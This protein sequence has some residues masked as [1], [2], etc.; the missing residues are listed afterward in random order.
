MRTLPVS[1]FSPSC[2]RSCFSLS[3]ILIAALCS[4]LVGAPAMAQEAAPLSQTAQAAAAPRPLITQLVDESQLTVLKGNTYP[5]ALPQNDLGTAPASLPM[6]RMLLVLKRSPEQE[7]ALIRMLDNQ[8]DKESPSYHQWVTPEQF[9]KQFGPTDADMQIIVAWLQ[10][11]GFQVGTTKGRSVL[12]FSGSA[13]QVQEAFHTTIHKYLV[14]GE[15]HWANDRDPSIPTAL[16]PAV[17]GI[18]SLHNFRKKPQYVLSKEKG[19][20][21]PGKPPQVNFSNGS[22]AMGPG[23]FAVIYNVNPV[24]S[25][26]GVT[27]SGIT[28]GVIARSD[29]L[30]S[31]YSDFVNFYG[32]S[33]NT[34]NFV[35]N[36]PDP[37]DLL[38]G[39]DVEGTLDATWSQAL[40]PGATVDYVVSASTDTTDGIDLSEAYIVENNL[41]NIMT[42]SFGGCEAFSGDAQFTGTALLAEQAAAQGISYFVSTGDAGAEGC[43]NPNVEAVATGPISINL[44]ASTP[45]TV[46]VGGTEFNDTGNPAKYW[47]ASNG[48]NLVSALSYIP[49]VVWNDSCPASSCGS[50]EN[51]AAG[52]GGESTGNVI[53]GGT[54]PGFAKPAWQTGVTGIPSPNARYLPDVSLTASGHDGY[55]ICYQGS[56]AQGSIYVIGGTSAS[57]PSFAAIMALV[58]ERMG[59]VE[60][61][62]NDGTRQGQPDYM[63][64]PL[65]A[66]ENGSLSSCNGSST[67]TLPA[68][69][70]VFNDV[71]VGNNEV[72]GEPGYPSAP[73][74]STVGYD[75]AVGLGSVNVNNLVTKWASATFRAT[76]TALTV[77]P[78]TGITH[79]QAVNVTIGVTPGSGTGT[80]TGDVS[81]IAA[82][83]SSTSGETS[84]DGFTLAAN[85]TFSGST[86]Q[87]PGGTY[88]VWAHYAGNSISTSSG[89][90][91]ASDSSKV[92][93][94]VG[95][96]GSTT[97]FICNPGGT[98]LTGCGLTIDPTSGNFV[99][100]TS[101][102]TIPYG[103]M[104]YLHAAVAGT[105]GFGVPTGTVSIKDNAVAVAGSPFAL[106]SDGSAVTPDGL[107]TLPAGSASLIAAYNHD[108]SF[109]ASTS[110]ALN[111]TITKA[112][113]SAS[114]SASPST[115]AAGGTS[116]LTATLT[117]GTATLPSFGNPPGATVSFFSNGTLLGSAP[118]TGTAGSGNPT[119][120]AFVNATGTASL[121]TTA[122][123][124]AT[125][126]DT[127]TAVYN[128]DSNYA[129]SPASSGITVTVQAPDFSISAPQIGVTQGNMTPVTITVASLGNFTAWS[130]D[131]LARTCLRRRHAARLLLR[132]SPVR[133]QPRLRSPPTRLARNGTGRRTIGRE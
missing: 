24:Y 114:V 129:A 8:Q 1:S 79:G 18:L 115:I 91:G 122:G 111:F 87:L 107:L 98:I 90:F 77:S 123:A 108:A 131:L 78:M 119:T 30:A 48:A 124:L 72:P 94:T 85:G 50:S 105:S 40:A 13:S 76:D 128:G 44:L 95:G 127:I 103:D 54:F 59:Q 37:G 16:T 27:G 112:L 109:N 7:F 4:L 106:S 132:R 69:T 36:G 38:N 113:T 6:E 89:I 92:S 49:E 22:H 61:A 57:T 34:P 110:A 5:L 75:P 96:E 11:H 47:S 73:Y 41:A 3:A 58:D 42:E 9:G 117:L 39:D 28:I 120:G 102:S 63:L 93:V 130:A 51:I 43:D 126:T 21:T 71:T 14:N 31:D 104:V 55:T 12:E 17:A 125:G 86:N 80:P 32:L 65:A 67:T 97:D 118:V 29:F 20:I 10:S 121:I 99:A 53:N 116:T 133:A 84:V 15:Q 56:C 70:C 82:T 46:G 62:S 74:N 64:Y 88:Q 100:L 60:P 101:G 19:I 81:L 68:S 2:S 23:D 25:A 33:A 83:G 26:M 45:F 35:F 66:G 52:G